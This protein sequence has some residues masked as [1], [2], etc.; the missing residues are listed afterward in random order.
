MSHAQAA[1]DLL[2]SLSEDDLILVLRDK[3]VRRA[4]AAAEHPERRLPL[5]IKDALVILRAHLEA[6]KGLGGFEWNRFD[7]LARL[8]SD[9]QPEITLRWGWECDREGHEFAS[10]VAPEDLAAVVADLARLGW[11]VESSEVAAS[12]SWDLTFDP[13]LIVGDVS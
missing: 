7:V 2:L 11:L 13:S 5:E 10:A 1:R 8:D 6:Q 3:V 12:T 4:L 9:A